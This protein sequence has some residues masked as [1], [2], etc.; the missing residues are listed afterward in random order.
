MSWRETTTR[1][2]VLLLV[3]AAL[4]A[5]A[6]VLLAAAANTFPRSRVR[7]VQSTAPP[8]ATVD[9]TGCP[10]GVRC[11]V[12]GT[13]TPEL[14]EAVTHRVPH[15][16]ILSGSRTLDARGLAYRSAVVASLGHDG[17]L[18]VAAQ[19]DPGAPPGRRYQMRNAVSHLDLAGNEVVDERT[20]TTV[21]PG[22]DGCTVSVQLRTRTDSAQLLAAA[23]RIADDAT[24]QLRR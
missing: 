18:E 10:V 1:R 22:R 24:V 19:C 15:A 9:A 16:V 20:V 2:R 13:A 8:A 23:V 11:L 5:A 4:L 6:L 3:A 12:T 21:V 14:T 7:I 17:V